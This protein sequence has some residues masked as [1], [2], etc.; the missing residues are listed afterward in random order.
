MRA[1]KTLVIDNYDSFTW[2]LVQ[3]LAALG[4]R[5]QV[6]RNDAVSLR[7]IEVLAP[8]RIVI[9]PGPGRP[10]D[11]GVSTEVIRRFAGKTDI[12]GVCL[13]HQCLAEVWGARVVHAPRPIHGKTSPV[14]HDGASVFH[15]LPRPLEAARYHSLA[16]SRRGLPACLE[17]TAWTADG[18]IMGL[19]HREHR[20]AGVQF[21]PESFLTP[22]GP[23]L[24][25]NFLEG[26]L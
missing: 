25:A 16:V 11:A 15:G 10:R 14:L 12:L 19:R 17:V 8:V 20:V 9:S 4:A 18:V 2:N 3:A 13:G 21:H 5:V 23:R 22:W 26:R 6:V 1:A 7:E 24:L